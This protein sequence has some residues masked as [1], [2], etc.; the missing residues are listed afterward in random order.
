MSWLFIS[1]GQ[2]IGA[3]ASASVLPRYSGLIYLRIDRFELLAVQGILKSPK[4][5]IF[6]F[7]TLTATM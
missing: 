3:A 1:G 6:S 5:L 7:G 2:S 4:L